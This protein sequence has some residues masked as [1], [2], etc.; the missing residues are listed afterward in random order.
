MELVPAGTGE[1]VRLRVAVGNRRYHATRLQRKTGIVALEDQARLLLNDLGEYGVW[2]DHVEGHDV[3][4]EE[5]AERWR[6]EVLEPTLAVLA[7]AIGG[8]RDPVQ[9]YCD[10]LEHKWLLSE[11]AGH[12]IGLETALTSYLTLGAPAPEAAGIGPDL[13]TDEERDPE[14]TT[15]DPE[16]GVDTT[17]LGPQPGRKSPT[18]Q[19]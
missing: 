12:D 14:A 6:S 3:S 5:T 4:A 8:D 18:R 11:M 1:R 13:E 16:F 7:A 17:R 10:L 15:V 9:A 2:L 19:A